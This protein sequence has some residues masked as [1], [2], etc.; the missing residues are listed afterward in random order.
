[1]IGGSGHVGYALEAVRRGADATVV[2]LAPGSPGEDLTG[3]VAACRAAGARPECFDS[4]ERLLEAGGLDAVVVA[5]WFGDH[6]RI[7]CAV[8]ERGL[9]C[10]LEKPV[11]LT[12]VDLAAL[13][14]AH[15]RAQTVLIPMLALRYAPAFYTA[16]KAIRTGAVGDVRLVTA[17]KSYRLGTRPPFYHQRATYGGTIPWVGSHAIDWMLWL[18][19]K[20]PVSVHASHSHRHNG[21]QG[22]MEVSAL[23]HFVLEDEVLGGISLDYLRPSC[24][25]THDD[26]QV[27]VAGTAGV[28]EVRHGQVHL[29]SDRAGGDAMLPLEHPGEL[30][31]DFLAAI[32]GERQPLC[33]HADGFRV[34][35]ACLLARQSAD[36]GRTVCW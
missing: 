13:E 21:G 24:A 4:F 12:L 3:V 34:T 33:N 29:L 14:A 36:E 31:D 23:C 18:S 20:Q 30:F 25:P 2:S 11:A 27:R 10:F 22:T 26:D 16:W 28:L 5:P 8:L 6:A 17:R 19:G 15:A 32:R 9:P 7:A 1:M 35:R